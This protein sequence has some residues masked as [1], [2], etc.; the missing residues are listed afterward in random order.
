MIDDF[1]VRAILAGAGLALIAGPLGCF[2]IWKRLAYFGDTP[3]ARS[4]VRNCAWTLI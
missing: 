1:F 3:L 2:V 4:T